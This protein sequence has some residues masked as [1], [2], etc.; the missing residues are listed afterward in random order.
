MRWAGGTTGWQRRHNINHLLTVVYE[1]R[2]R[3]FG[4]LAVLESGWTFQ[5]LRLDYLLT[6]RLR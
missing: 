2:R 5:S 1:E 6:E 4:R 3:D